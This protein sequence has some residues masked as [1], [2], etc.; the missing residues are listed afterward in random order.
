MI[1]QVLNG[2][3]AGFGVFDCTVLLL[4]HYNGTI[5]RRHAIA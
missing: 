4:H 2:K 3:S 1:L 5:V